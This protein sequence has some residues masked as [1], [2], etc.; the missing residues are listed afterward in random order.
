M[1]VTLGGFNPTFPTY[2]L[3]YRSNCYRSDYLQVGVKVRA[4]APACFSSPLLCHHLHAAYSR[5]LIR[6]SLEL[7]GTAA[8][9]MVA[10]YTFQVLRGR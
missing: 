5:P 4:C 8:L 1:E 3:C 9:K 7:H 2:G 6:V 10:T